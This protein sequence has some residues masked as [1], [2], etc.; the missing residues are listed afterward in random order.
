MFS[1]GIQSD[2]GMKWI[3]GSVLPQ[4]YKNSLKV[5]CI[6]AAAVHRFF[7]NS[8]SLFSFCLVTFTLNDISLLYIVRQHQNTADNNFDF[9]T[10]RD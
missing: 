9:K 6:T 4:I 10:T 7:Q 5:C 1:G 8:S 2:I 3:K